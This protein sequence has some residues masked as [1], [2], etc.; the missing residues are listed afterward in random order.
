M[1]VHKQFFS[2]LFFLCVSILLLPATLSATTAPQAMYVSIPGPTIQDIIQKLLPL[3][4]EHKGSAF[5]GTVTLDELDSL[6]IKNNL[7]TV[8]GRVSG[9]NMAM[10]TRI[11]GR[12]I[13]LKVGSMTLPVNCDLSLR[14]D[15]LK[16]ILYVTPHFNDPGQVTSHSAK[17]LLPLLNSL[18]NR[19]YPLNFSRINPFRAQVGSKDFAFKLK[20]ITMKIQKN[21]LVLQVVPQIS[22]G[23]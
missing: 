3:P 13:K 12:N 18:S 4:I 2:K 5:T 1:Y 16:Q 22:S 17:T 9:K 11:G 15:N 21:K 20:P 23:Q 8:K 10:F 19:E 14:F 6:K 7:I